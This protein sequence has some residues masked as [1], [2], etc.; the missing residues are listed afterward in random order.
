[1]TVLVLSMHNEEQYAVR[2]IKAGALGYLTKGGAAEQL[3][4]AVAKVATGGPYITPGV[5]ERLALE[6]RAAQNLEPHKLLSDREFEILRMIVAGKKI[7]DIALDLSLSDKTVS[8]YKARILQKMRM[9]NTAELIHYAIDHGLSA[10][11]ATA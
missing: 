5:A 8:T 4:N 6:F 2:A 10:D 11:S 7:G 1:M 9:K 3:I